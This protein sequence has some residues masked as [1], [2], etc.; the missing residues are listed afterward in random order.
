MQSHRGHCVARQGRRS[1]VRAKAH[2]ALLYW[3]YRFRGIIKACHASMSLHSQ[4]IRDVIDA[5]PLDVAVVATK[6]MVGLGHCTKRRTSSVSGRRALHRDV[7]A[8]QSP[9]CCLVVEY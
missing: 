2:F 5:A 4:R 6:R 8:V 3:F 1:R 9:E 7:V